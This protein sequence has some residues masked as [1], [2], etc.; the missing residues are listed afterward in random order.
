M[1]SKRDRLWESSKKEL[2]YLETQTDLFVASLST[3][4][5]SRQ[6]QTYTFETV[7]VTFILIFRLALVSKKF[8]M[9]DRAEYEIFTQMNNCENILNR[10]VNFICKEFTLIF[11]E[12]Y[13]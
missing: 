7:K 5:S 9:T 10:M 3:L 12:K 13:V 8:M 6:T 2:K 11:A 1:T 4:A